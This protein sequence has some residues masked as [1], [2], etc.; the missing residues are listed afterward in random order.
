MLTNVALIACGGAFGAVMR[1]LIA[2]ATERLV[3]GRAAAA[4][5]VGTLT[6]NLVGCMLIGIGAAFLTGAD[7]A[8]A[9]EPWRMLLLVGV[10]GGFTTFST[11]GLETVTLLQERQWMLAI[12]YVLASNIG[13]IGL[14]FAAFR[15]TQLGRG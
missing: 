15:V 4:F 13:G 6:V 11:F 5:P 2:N 7:D 1:F 14:V 8:A 3:S 10:L 9:K 12:M